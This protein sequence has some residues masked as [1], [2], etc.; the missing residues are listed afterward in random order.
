MVERYGLNQDSENAQLFI[1]HYQYLK[2]FEFKYTSDFNL[3][4]F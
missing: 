4:M 3:I 1:L 2:M